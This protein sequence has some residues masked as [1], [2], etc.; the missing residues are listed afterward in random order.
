MTKLLGKAVAELSKLPEG[1]QDAIAAWLLEELTSERRWERLF[2]TSHDALAVL[3]E[4]ALAEHRQG[5]TQQLE[6]D[7]L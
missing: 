5:G 2:S 3:A 1:E 6:P 7:R 4:E